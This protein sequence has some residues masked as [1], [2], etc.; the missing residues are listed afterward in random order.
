MT[1]KK[2]GIKEDVKDV[3]VPQLSAIEQYLSG[4]IPNKKAFEDAGFPVTYS[5]VPDVKAWV[6]ELKRV[7]QTQPG[8]LDP[9]R[10]QIAVQRVVISVITSLIGK[11]PDVDVS[12]LRRRAT[13]MIPTMTRKIVGA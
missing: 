4:R 6:E 3:A 10:V 8:E 9:I 5:D 12:E 2:E 11:T 13:S 1:D 7:K